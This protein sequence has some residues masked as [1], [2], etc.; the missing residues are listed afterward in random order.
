MKQFIPIVMLVML[1]SCTYE[2]VAEVENPDVKILFLHHSTGKCIWEGDK[3]IFA[4]LSK[5]H[6]QPAVPWLISEYNR[7][8]GKRYAITER[9]FPADKPYGWKNYPFDYYTIWV[10]HAG[11]SLFQNEPTLEILTREYNVI[12]FKHCFP[13]SSMQENEAEPSAESEVKTLANYKLQYDSLKKKLH[14]FPDTK[15]IL[16]TGAALVQAKTNEKQAMLADEF[17]TWVKKEW[18]TP[19]DNIYIWDFRQLETNGGLYLAK[20]N[21]RNSRDSHPNEQFSEKAAVLFVSRIISVIENN[22]TDTDL[23][24]AIKN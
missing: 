2:P 7:Q 12:V 20:N 17:F 24:G 5:R 16:W 23:T 18:D 6:N 4:F 1:V 21:A 22:G 3:K 13:V 9:S 8:I 15:F 11:D 19:D 10:K 14:S